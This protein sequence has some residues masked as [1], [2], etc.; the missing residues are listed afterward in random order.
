MRST[1]PEYHRSERIGCDDGALLIVPYLVGWSI[2]IRGAG[3]PH[4]LSMAGIVIGMWYLGGHRLA[5]FADGE[6]LRV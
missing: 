2:D 5:S 3:S 4:W 1:H 6:Q